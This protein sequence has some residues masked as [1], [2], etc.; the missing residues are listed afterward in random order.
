VANSQSCRKDAQ[1]NSLAVIRTV[2]AAPESLLRIPPWFTRGR[3]TR[4]H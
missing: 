1:T 2:T 3:Y 4:R